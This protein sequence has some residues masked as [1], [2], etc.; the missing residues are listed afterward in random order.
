M[1]DTKIYQAVWNKYL[2]VIFIKIKSAVKKNELQQFG[3]DKIDFENASHRKNTK[4][5][6]T[7][8]LNEGR[9]II[10]KNISPVAR[11]F[12]RALND[13]EMTKNIIKTGRFVFTL[14]NKFIL[15]IQANQV[16]SLK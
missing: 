1:S 11:D 14:N 6:F 8:E 15:S 5:Q 3:I 13:S 16:E 10:S 9:T 2:P 7:L 12:A 4:F